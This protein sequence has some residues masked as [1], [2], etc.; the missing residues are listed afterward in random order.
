MPASNV[1]NTPSARV[2]GVLMHPTSLPGPHGSGDCGPA[3]YHFVDWLVA[4]G[5]Q[6]WQ[7]L[8]LN[9]I[10]AGDSPYSSASALAGNPLL[11]DLSELHHQGWLDD[12]Q[13][14]L[15]SGMQTHAVNFPVVRAYRMTCLAAACSHFLTLS[16]TVQARADFRTFCEQQQ[17]WLDDYSLFMALN[18]AHDGQPWCQ[19][20]SA[21][22]RREPAAL[23]LAREQ[24]SR[25]VLFWQFCQWTFH[26][27][28]RQLKDYANSRGIRIVG[29]MPIF[30]AHHSADV[31]AR[32]DLFLLQPSGMPSV[33]AGVPPDYF[34][35]TGQRWGNPLYDWP[36]HRKEHFAW[37]VQRLRGA[38]RL[39]D[40][41]R[42][43]HFRGFAAHWEIPAT[44][45]T[46]MRGRW[47]KGPGAALFKALADALGPL[48]VIA[49][50]LGEITADVEA[51][52]RRLGFPGMR[53]L[54][55][56]FGDDSAN[57]YLP[58]RYAR[59]S[60]V[61]PGTHDN[62]TTAGWWTQASEHERN[63]AR[64]Y[65]GVD[66]IKP[67]EPQ[68]DE[69]VAMNWALIR[70]ACAS[71]AD[72]AIVAMQDV[73]ALPSTARMNMPGDGEGCWQWRLQW[74]QVQPH[75]ADRLAALCRLYG[76]DPPL[77]VNPHTP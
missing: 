59:D 48:P 26:R 9:P 47:R 52:R 42:I 50:D 45:S 64:A 76:R 77:P 68:D 69:A 39:V 74:Q 7:I 40:S 8:P 17:S 56:A 16:D 28:W 41:V 14:H 20:P 54:Q 62:D 75:H 72:T 60:V 51:L 10:G 34:S 21:L 35:A 15:P 44:E 61:Y 66:G 3:A 18:D 43:D 70:A 38:L 24:Y 58:H 12:A 46:A 23:A 73:L 63:F 37:W 4:A 71:V 31:W 33:V 1:A 11:I 67:G 2:S 32:P 5:Q 22:A 6:L 49:E 53:I 36:R 27:Q 55:F 19:W 57:P 13:M 29:D 25:E 30:V 65:L